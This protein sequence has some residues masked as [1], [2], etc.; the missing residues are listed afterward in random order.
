M[1]QLNLQGVKPIK[2]NVIDDVKALALALWE[3]AI[4]LVGQH[5][6]ESGIILGAVFLMLVL[7]TANAFTSPQVTADTLTP[8]IERQ[9]RQDC[10]G[11]L[12]AKGVSKEG[13]ISGC[14]GLSAQNRVAL[15]G[16]TE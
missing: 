16:I 8:D 6:V 4:E 2:A 7:A 3:Q 12:N 13:K 5:K 9:V 10:A 11:I 1:K 14:I 15:K